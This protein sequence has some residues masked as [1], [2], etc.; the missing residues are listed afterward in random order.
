MYNEEETIG[1]VVT[2]ALR[3][4]DEVICIDDGSSDSSARIA[5]AC[6]A[7]VIRHRGNQ[8]YGAA[9][10]TLF[11]AT[12]DSDADILVV[13]D[14]DGQHD[15]ADIPK[16]IQPILDEEADFTIGSRFVEGGE[17][18]DMPAYRRLGIKVITAA[19]NLTRISASRTRNLASEHSLGKPLTAYVLMQTEWSSTRDARRC[20]REATHH[21]RNPDHHPLRCSKG[22]NFTA[23]SHGF[24]VLTWALLS[25]SQKKPLLT[26]GIPGLGLLATGAAMGMNTAQGFTTQIDTVLGQGL[27]AVWIGVLGLALIATGFILQTVR[28]FLRILLVREFGLD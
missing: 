14:S 27:T 21:S 10:K 12:R 11:K 13:L 7:T 3:H 24:T 20:E 25:L 1:T 6:G 2:M 8:G 17:G 18:N 28:G 19:S 22:S 26:L 16:L 9:L 4:V 15:T 5:E 23:L